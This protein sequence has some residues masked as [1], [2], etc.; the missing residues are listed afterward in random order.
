MKFVAGRFTSSL[1]LG[2]TNEAPGEIRLD[3][4]S[5]VAYNGTNDRPPPPVGDRHLMYSAI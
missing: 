4:S 1:R 2:L 5:E 3:I